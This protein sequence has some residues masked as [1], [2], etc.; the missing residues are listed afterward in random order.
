MTFRGSLRHYTFI[1]FNDKIR[2]SNLN[3]D[4]TLVFGS[5]RRFTFVIT[6]ATNPAMSPVQSKNIWKESLINPDKI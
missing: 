4:S 5:S 2:V 6:V 3:Y 1:R